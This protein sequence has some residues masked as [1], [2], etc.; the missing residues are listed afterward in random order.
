[1]WTLT[2]VT[3][4]EATAHRKVSPGDAETKMENYLDEYDQVTL[5]L[6]AR[7]H[8]PTHSFSPRFEDDSGIDPADEATIRW[9]TA[10]GPVSDVTP[11][12]DYRDV[13]SQVT[14]DGPAVLRDTSTTYAIPPDWSATVNEFGH[15]IITMEES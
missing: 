15:M 5:R 8:L 1:M 7:A 11:L 3:G 14:V 4:D 10:E 13:T 6:R 12:Y 9:Q 2:G